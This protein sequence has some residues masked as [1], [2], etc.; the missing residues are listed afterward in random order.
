MQILFHLTTAIYSNNSSEISYK[1]KSDLQWTFL[2]SALLNFYLCAC[3]SKKENKK[4]TLLII[5]QI[6]K[7][8]SKIKINISKFF[9]IF[10]YYNINQ[11][12]N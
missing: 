7:V 6:K 3:V 2:R 4:Q 12:S 8:K 1:N 9:Y 11:I 10:S 5:F